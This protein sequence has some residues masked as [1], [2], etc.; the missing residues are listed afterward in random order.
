MGRLHALKNRLI[1][2]DIKK[3][4]ERSVGLTYSTSSKMERN[5]AIIIGGII[6]ALINEFVISP[7]M[8]NVVN[9]ILESTGRKSN[10]SRKM[11]RDPA[12]FL[13]TLAEEISNSRD[14]IS[15]SYDYELNKYDELFNSRERKEKI[16]TSYLKKEKK[17]NS[18]LY[19]KILS[20]T[21]LFNI[22]PLSS[23]HYKLFK[24]TL[25]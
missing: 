15:R 11:E 21:F 22:F 3:L 23:Y 5:F 10:S 25:L 18:S 1:Q 14:Y 9:N 20:K 16:V 13:T 17:R 4:L 8:D 7:L 19:L 2:K 24:R 6:R 12:K